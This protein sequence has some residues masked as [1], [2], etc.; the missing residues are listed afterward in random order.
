MTCDQPLALHLRADIAKSNLPEPRAHDS[1]AI[2]LTARGKTVQP[3]DTRIIARAPLPP[4]RRSSARNAPLHVLSV[5]GHPMNRE[6][7]NVAQMNDDPTNTVRRA[8]APQLLFTK[9]DHP[10]NDAPKRVH[11]VSMSPDTAHRATSPA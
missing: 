5:P 9:A 7:M 11:A 3:A 1:A 10:A 4:R 2:P 6:P 8:T